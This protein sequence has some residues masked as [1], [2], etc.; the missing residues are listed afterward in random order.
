MHMSRVFILPIFILL[1][2]NPCEIEFIGDTAVIAPESC[3]PGSTTYD[4]D[5]CEEQPAPGDI[6]G[7]CVDGS[8]NGIDVFC[9]MHPS[10]SVCMPGCD[11]AGPECND[12]GPECNAGGCSGGTCLPN[13]AC[14]K[15]CEVDA[16]CFDGM[17]C[18]LEGAGPV[19]MW[20]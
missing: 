17:H 3:A 10:G 15:L 2:C 4:G 14:A 6:W 12:A 20:G 8:C 11:D 1:A 13:G 9:M 7:P 5:V 19:C 16:D 18:N